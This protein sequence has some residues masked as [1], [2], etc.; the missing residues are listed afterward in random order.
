MRH[1]VEDF[2][3]GLGPG[4]VAVV[5]GEDGAEDE[6]GEEEVGVVVDRAGVKREIRSGYQ[7]RS[8]ED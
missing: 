6:A 8:S 3:E 5:A 4:S 7:S 2:E 1:L